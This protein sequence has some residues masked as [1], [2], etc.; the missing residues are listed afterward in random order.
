MKFSKSDI[1]QKFK[2]IPH[3]QFESEGPMTA[4]GGLVLFQKLFGVLDLKARLCR[5]FSHLDRDAIFRHGTSM[6]LLIVQILLGQRRLRGR[7]LLAGDPLVKRVLGVTA[8]P[9]VAT[10]SRMLSSA[11]ARSVEAVR[12]LS[13]EVVLDR[14]A[15]EELR[16]ATLDFDGS[17]QSTKGHAEGT[18]VGF[19]K[20]RK[21]ARS[22]YL[23]FCTLAQTGQVLDRHH[24]SGNVHDSNGAVAFM[25]QCR[26]AVRD[27]LPGARIE[28][29][30]DSAFFEEGL[31]ASL[32]EDG[33][34]FTGS[35][36]F[37]R[38]PP[39][40]QKLE[41]VRDWHRINDTWSYATCDWRPKSWTTRNR[42]LL[43]RKKCEVQR[44]GPLQLDLFEPRDYSYDYKVIVTNK[45]DHPRTVLH[46]HNGR[47]SQEKIFGECKQYAALDVIPTRTLHG[48]QL[49]TL[50]SLLVHN[51]SRELQMR[52]APAT[53]GTDP[54]RPARWAF[55]SLGTLRQRLVCRVGR[56]LRPQGRLT[57]RMSADDSV[58]AEIN[59]YMAGLRRAA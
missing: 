20:V 10:M 43:M 50:A 13:R 30:F 53:R 6:L 2:K 57:L 4:F 18:A 22:Y 11:D 23:L 26:D 42:I 54:K 34:E 51:L 55:L 59:Q 45:L 32:D 39:L 44:K 48:N 33:V 12:M 14:V 19:N 46:F 49:F 15:S 21:G 38:F 36:P 41:A 8:L 25:K 1:R 31:L 35:V 52:A 5:C 28:T 17:V 29:R 7:D 16:V 47:G 3:L 40:K 24:R 27:R 37:E 58:A 56:L 9:D